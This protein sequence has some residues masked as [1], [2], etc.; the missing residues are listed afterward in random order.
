LKDYKNTHTFVEGKDFA[1][2]G[3]SIHWLADG[4]KPDLKKEFMVQYGS[5]QPVIV[6]R[7][8]IVSTQPQKNQSELSFQTTDDCSLQKTGG[9]KWEGDAEVHSI[10]VGT[11]GNVLP[12]TIKIMP[13]PVEG[14]DKVINRSN[15]AGGAGQEDDASLRT[16]AKKIL[17]V[18]GKATLESLRTALE[19]IEGIQTPPVLIDMP[20]G[21]QGIVK[22]IID[23]GDD[24]VIEKV[25]EE[26]RAAGIRVEYSR[27]KMVLLDVAGVLVVSK[28]SEDIQKIISTSETIIRNFVSSLGIGE[29]LVINQ[30]VS[31]LLETS[32]VVDVRKLDINAI[33]D[34]PSPVSLIS[35]A[36]AVGGASSSSAA[37][38]EEGSENNI[39]IS[40][41]ERPYIREVQV[42][43][44]RQMK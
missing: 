43:V 29:S 27:P 19:G 8:T 40:D 39:I 6:P 7:G 12:G 13:T 44:V 42:K 15:L 11:Q 5:F 28:T 1:T 32:G 38:A 34:S 17:D 10:A 20:D 31:L 23:G 37:P 9:G 14:I 35:A 2:E 18:K 22:A 4:D 36:A 26:T 24:S 33:R 25:I 16:R 21:V 3:D 30:L 41:E